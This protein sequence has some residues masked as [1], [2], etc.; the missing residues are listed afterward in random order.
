[1]AALG[2]QFYDTRKRRRWKVEVIIKRFGTNFPNLV[3]VLFCI[4]DFW[5]DR[6]IYWRRVD[7]FFDNH[8]VCLRLL[9]NRDLTGVYTIQVLLY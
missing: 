2:C 6:S 1:M 5:E 3:V 4:W 7:E 9:Q 8:K